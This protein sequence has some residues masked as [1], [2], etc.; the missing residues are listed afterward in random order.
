MR[1]EEFDSEFID[2][3]QNKVDLLEYAISQ[4]FEFR[5]NGKENFTNCP[6]H[7]DNTPSLSITKDEDG[8]CRKFYC[9]SCKMGGSIIRW[10]TQIEGLGFRES[11]EKA[12]KLANM[13]MSKMCKSP[14]VKYLRAQNRIQKKLE[15]K[16]VF[17]PVLNESLFEKYDI[18]PIPE[19][20]DEGIS[21]ETIREFDIRVDNSSN[22]IVYA[23]RNKDG[24]LINIKGRTR[25][26]EFKNMKIPKYKN[27]Y[28]LIDLD[29]FQSLDKAKSYIEQKDEMIVVESIKSV[30]K[31]WDW[32]IKNV[33]SAETH[34]LTNGQLRQIL[35][36]HCNKVVLAFDKD[37]NYYEKKEEGLRD[38]MNKIKRFVNLYYIYDTENLLGDKDSP[39]DKGEEVWRYL[40]SRK[41]R[42]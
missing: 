1:Y 26:Q 32:G 9:H 10:L 25:Y 36:L 13:D 6:L 38:Q 27:Y 7:T 2:E 40:Y 16:I 15:Q 3:I 35:E 39:M 22:R 17:H 8:V 11:V 31:C 12:S 33:V 30:M 42:W 23:V 18:E 4:G 28:K 14:V 34:A 5:T 24:E 19:W 21:R 20:E 29:F 41:R 37:V